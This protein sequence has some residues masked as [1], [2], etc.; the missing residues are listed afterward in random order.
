MPP[1][2]LPSKTSSSA[3]RSTMSAN[4]LWTKSPLSSEH[5][6]P[7]H[8]LVQHSLLQAIGHRREVRHLAEGRHRVRDVVLAH[9]RPLG[10]TEEHVVLGGHPPDVAGTDLA[11]AAEQT[12]AVERD[13]GAGGG[14]RQRHGRDVADERRLDRL[15]LHRQCVRRRWSALAV[16]ESVAGTTVAGEEVRH[17]DGADDLAGDE[18]VVVGRVDHLRDRVLGRRIA[19]Q[20]E[21]LVADVQHALAEIAGAGDGEVPRE[22]QVIPLDAGAGRAR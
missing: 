6:P 18:T 21:R 16:R 9:A 5:R 15:V 13:A 19:E 17:D 22:V 20:V 2:L 1:W 14:R 7:E 8:D 11:V 10:R 4:E 3:S 12:V